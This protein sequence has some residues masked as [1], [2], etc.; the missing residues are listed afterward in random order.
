M[1][2]RFAELPQLAWYQERQSSLA[3]GAI[4]P[5]VACFLAVVAL[6]LFVESLALSVGGSWSSVLGLLSLPEKTAVRE[7]DERCKFE[8]EDL[9][10]IF[11]VEW[12]RDGKA[13]LPANGRY[14]QYQPHYYWLPLLGLFTGARLNELAQLYLDDFAQDEGDTW[15]IDFNLNADDKLSDGVLDKSLKTVNSVRQI[16]IH[17]KL[18]ELGLVEYVNRLRDA[19]HARLFPE[20]RFD[21]IKGYG[22]AAGKWFNDRFLGSKL[23][24]PRDGMRTFHSFRHTFTSAMYDFNEGISEP[25]VAQFT[26]HQRGETMS[27]MRYRKD[28]AATRQLV[29]VNN[30][31]FDLPD[32]ARFDIEAGM[33]ALKNA[34]GRK[35]RYQRMA[36]RSHK[37]T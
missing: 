2:H 4:P 16:A 13:V 23:G 9:H 31:D 15:F 27:A 28:K 36:E 5:H 22:K 14:S 30:L 25:T 7:Q 21:K 20:L 19:G 35:E 3:V 34:L 12:F 29:Y 33:L 32:I 1:L 37:P 11:S 18:I 8:K 10:R 26:G 17:K 24:I 6:A